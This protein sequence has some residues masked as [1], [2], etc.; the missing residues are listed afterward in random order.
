MKEQKP[1]RGKAYWR[2]LD[3]LAETPEFKEFLFREFPQGASEFDNRWSRR[4]FL[5]LM[6]ASVALAGLASCR[7][8]VENVV[9]FV[10]QPE[11]VTP[12]VPQYYA[13][14]MPFGVSSYGV[15]VKSNDGRPTKIEGNELHP[16]SLGSTDILMQA[17]ILQM[18]D[19]DRS[20]LALHKGVEASW[21]GF[22]SFWRDKYRAFAS[23]QGQGLAIL[24]QGFN[25]PTLMRLAASL[26]QQFPKMIWA[27]YEAISDE[28]I[29]AGIRLATGKSLLP[30]YDFSQA[31]VIL[32][33][34][35]DF[36][37]TES[38]S[39]S[40]IRGFSDG[41]RVSTKSDEMNRL[42]AVESGYS[43]TGAKADHRLRMQSRLVGGFAAALARELSVPAAVALPVGSFSAEEQKWIKAVA[44]DLAR[45]RG[46]GLVIAGR[47]QPA[48]VHAL[49]CAINGALGNIGKTV[50]FV[51]PKDASLPNR[52]ELKTLAG[53]L[54]AGQVDTLVI[55]GGNPVYDAP[56]DLDFAN[57]LG[58]A[59][60]TVHL[61]LFEDETSQKCEWH[62]PEAH[63]L[64][65]WGDTR[66]VDGTVGSI[67]PLIEPLYG[68]HSLTEF[69]SLLA[70]GR[71]QRGY[72]IVRE[73]WQKQFGPLTFEASWRKMIHDG[74][75]K[76]SVLPTQNAT[77]DQ[78]AVA[79]AIGAK[80]FATS[81]S[82]SF[83]LTLVPSQLYDGRFANNAWLQ[84]LPDSITKLTWD[85]VVSISP[86]DARKLGL[87]NGD[88]VRL[89]CQ[90]R[91]LEMPVW[92]QPGQTDGSVALSVG[93]GRSAAGRVG[94]GVGRNTYRLRT[95]AEYDYLAGV[96]ITR[97]GRHYKLST[98]QDHGSME[99]RAIVREATLDG[100]KR[101]EKFE[102]DAP[103]HP[104]LAAL[105]DEHKYDTG[106]QWGMSID[107]TACTACNACTIACQSENNIPVVGKEQV[108]NGRE[109]HW[110]RIDRY[111]SGKDES[112]EVSYQPMGC[113][114]CENAPCE[115][116]C[117]VA[118]TQ[119]DAEGLNVMVYNRCI[120]TRY[121]SNNCP[122]KVRRFNFFNYTKDLPETVRMQQNPDVTV[123]SRG[124]M[125]K[126]TYC[127]QRIVAG[128][129]HAKLEGRLVK[130]GEIVTACQQACPAKAITFG[131]ILNPTSKV[132]QLKKLDR[133][134]S[135]LE[136]FN[137]RPRTTYLALLR[138]PN[139]EL[140][141]NSILG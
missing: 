54:E 4:S 66:S 29:Y 72:D 74:V 140:E 93:Y 118:A 68:G 112:P 12:G 22:V 141:G 60:S 26:K 13:S 116:V 39:V 120:G 32:S 45:T 15:L 56:A 75:L 95:V 11:E 40:A 108:A 1:L 48:E 82:D 115:S 101:G 51:E 105:W 90:G 119:H 42:Y 129:S 34:D 55:L 41:R 2:S 67:Q 61:G 94:D 111:Y 50:S 77:I 98:V 58:K 59:R 5:T 14:T 124:V 79:R 110:I 136:E 7:R 20:R 69:V 44:K 85:N 47:K 46:R 96:S 62:I 16:S 138:N 28:N 128:K 114:H 31:G 71:E 33:L 25:S 99:G 123:R 102:P 126:C 88:L 21:E 139:P 49:V 130:D 103:E 43:V 125:E 23:N 63:F 17:A 113:Q 52:E 35:S 135:V 137:T 10:V 87:S 57:L 6:G 27:T 89:D 86:Q 18:Y 84:E 104:P 131:D 107:L 117:P 106:Y 8:P 92:I 81:K 36:L 121:C 133:T 78:S 30:V 134:Y 38:E 127:V 65:S 53:N 9:P 19:P 122:Y 91:Q 100:Y 3:Q 132:S 73:T 80:P 24:S 109:M 97:L 76:D 37:K 70:N 83:E 64:E